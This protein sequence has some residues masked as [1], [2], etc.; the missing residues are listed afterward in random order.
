MSKHTISILS[1]PSLNINQPKTAV[2]RG[3]KLRIS[4]VSTSGS[5]YKALAEH[6]NVISVVIITIAIFL[7]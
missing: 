3:I 2:K 7:N 5:T 4:A 1:K 6:T